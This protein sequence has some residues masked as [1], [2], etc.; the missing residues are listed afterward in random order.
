M[1]LHRELSGRSDNKIGSLA[2][3]RVGTGYYDSESRARPDRILAVASSFLRL[4]LSARLLRMSQCPDMLV[5]LELSLINGL[6]R[7]RILVHIL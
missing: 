6:V 2:S 4:E 3:K 7:I 1:G 5:S